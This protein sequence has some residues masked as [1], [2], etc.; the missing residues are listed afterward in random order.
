MG[1]AQIPPSAVVVQR[2]TVA[3]REVAAQDQAAPPAVKADHEVPAVGSVDGD[4]GCGSGHTR[5]LPEFG[6]GAVDD[7]DKIWE[8]A[9]GDAVARNVAANNLGD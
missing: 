7:R 1:V 3:Y 9:C 4:S 5:G 2:K 8:F 6:E